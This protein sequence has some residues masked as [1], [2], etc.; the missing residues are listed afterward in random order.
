[1]ATGDKR[2]TRNL[3]GIYAFEHD[4]GRPFDGGPPA[5]MEVISPPSISTNAWTMQEKTSPDAVRIDACWL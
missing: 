5:I 3:H 2:R 1:M 4:V